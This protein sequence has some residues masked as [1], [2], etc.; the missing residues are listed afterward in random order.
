M[1]VKAVSETAE[2]GQS[3][4]P[5]D[6]HREFVHMLPK[7]E[8]H[9]RI[10]FRSLKGDNRDE[11]VQEAVCNACRAFARLSEQGRAEAATWSSLARFAIRQVRD[12]RRVGSSQNVRDVC[13]VHCKRRHGVTIEP[14]SRWD[15]EDGTW[16][17]M[18][19]EDK[20]ATPADLAASRIDVPAFFASLSRRNRR[21]AQKLATG[22]GTKRV[23]KMFGISPGRVSQLRQELKAAWEQFHEPRL[24]PTAS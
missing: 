11:A 22:E 10:A 8:R 21:I 6:W 17:D 15:E 2:L 14:L 16:R 5:P 13:S 9:A 3:D 20:N 1:I 4:V 7:I 23:A 18:L 19:V 12:G 24:A